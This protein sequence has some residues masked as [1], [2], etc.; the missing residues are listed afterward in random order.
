MER[1]ALS[2]ALVAVNEASASSSALRSPVTSRSRSTARPPDTRPSASTKRPPVVRRTR[3]KPSPLALRRSTTASNNC[4]SPG[5]SHEPK[6]RMR[7]D[8]VPSARILRSPSMAGSLSRPAH[9]TTTCGSAAN[10]TSARSV[11][12]RRSESS[13]AS[14]RSRFSQRWRSRRCR[15]AVTAENIARPSRTPRPVAL[16]G[17]ICSDASSAAVRDGAGSAMACALT[18]VVMTKVVMAKAAGTRVAA[19]RP[20][21]RKRVG[22]R[23]CAM[24]LNGPSPQARHRQPCQ[25]APS[26]SRSL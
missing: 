12:A 24:A 21:R 23:A 7:R 16:L 3:R 8:G 25:A 19:Q 14:A 18:K 5:P 17:S 13:A 6:A 2:S 15:R 4:A 1:T 9:E 26:E 11:R 10:S 22:K 20:V